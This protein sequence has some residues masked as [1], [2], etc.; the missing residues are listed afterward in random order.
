MAQA[1]CW[2]W[3]AMSVTPFE[4]LQTSLQ[5]FS[6]VWQRQLSCAHFFNSDMIISPEL[7]MRNLLHPVAAGP[8]FL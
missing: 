6:V 4:S 3:Q 5:Y 1:G 7:G 8:G 2:H